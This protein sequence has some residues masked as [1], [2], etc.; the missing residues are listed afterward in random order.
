[1]PF[2]EAALM[3]RC[4]DTG[5]SSRSFALR[6]AS[7]SRS[8]I[9]AASWNGNVLVLAAPLAANVNHEGTAFAGSVHALATL[10]GWSAVWL[11][12]R[13]AASAARIVIQDSRMA[14]Q[15]P[16]AED[17]QASCAVPAGGLERLLNALRR[18]G[19]GRIALEVD[20]RGGG[21]VLAR[22]SGRYVAFAGER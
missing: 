18:H 9:R 1:L 5:I 6:P 3:P 7:S 2:H 16:I 20:V 8:G 15:L 12:L 19:R 21:A 11:S 17:F 22:F 13:R 14:Y 10:A 4:W